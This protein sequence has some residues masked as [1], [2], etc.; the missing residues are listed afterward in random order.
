MEQLSDER[1]I[2]CPWCLEKE[3]ETWLLRE[4]DQY[5]C[6]QCCFEGSRSDVFNLYKK[7]EQK[8]VP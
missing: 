8:R 5:R 6:V 4:G 1:P 7:L 3:V 2:R